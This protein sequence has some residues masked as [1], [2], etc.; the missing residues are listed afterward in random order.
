MQPFP[1]MLLQNPKGS[2]EFGEGG[3]GG[4]RTRLL[5]TGFF[6]SHDGIFEAFAEICEA[7]RYF[8]RLSGWCHCVCD[9]RG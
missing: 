4:A 1:T 9:P 2:A 8:P 7:P 3:Q 5:R 6:S